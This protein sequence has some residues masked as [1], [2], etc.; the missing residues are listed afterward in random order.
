MPESVTSIDVA[1]SN[2]NLDGIIDPVTTEYLDVGQS[3]EIRIKRIYSYTSYDVSIGQD[4]WGVLLSLS[5]DSYNISLSGTELSVLDKT[6]NAYAGIIA[7]TNPN[8]WG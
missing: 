3:L 2:Q 5:D 7:S 8:P 4:S 1:W 6:K